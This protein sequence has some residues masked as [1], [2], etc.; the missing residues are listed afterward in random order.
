M[1]AIY[2]HWP[3]CLSKCAYCGFVSGSD[4][5]AREAYSEALLREIRWGGGLS[6]AP[7]DTIFLGGG[8]PSLCPPPL[9]RAV[10]ETLRSSFEVDPAAEIT[11]E[12][13]PCTA[14]PE[15]LEAARG[16][17]INRIS[18]GLQAA[19]DTHL[20]RLGR[21]HTARQ[22]V[23]ACREVRRAGFDNLNTDLIYGLP[24]QTMAQWV[25][26]LQFAC[27][28]EPDHISCYALSIEEETPL[29]AC[30]AAG[31][32]LPPDEDLAADMYVLARSLVMGRGFHQYEVSNFSRPGRECRHNLKYWQR[33][34]YLGFG[35]SAHSLLGL[36]RFAN[37]ESV[38]EYIQTWSAGVPATVCWDLADAAERQRE[39]LMLASRL[40][41]GFSPAEFA[42][43]CGSPF[44]EQGRRGLKQALDDGLLRRRDGRFVPTG[45]GLRFQNRLAGLLTADV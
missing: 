43:V 20:Q 19:Q 27:D 9:L 28:L 39:F 17:G 16:V 36:L 7:V 42:A 44:S 8:T 23:S 4:L 40:N 22:F 12:V 26:S 1:P 38:T 2:I 31:T 15:W 3:F 29:A 6:S 30:L 45:L 14:S 13:N 41:A 21:R 34:D 24:D 18:M 32:V 5:S 10:F 37:T 25:E 11:A 35:A 33:Q